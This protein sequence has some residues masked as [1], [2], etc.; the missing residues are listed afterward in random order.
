MKAKRVRDERLMLTLT[1]EEREHIENEAVK[2]GMPMTVYCRM[3]LMKAK[4]QLKI[5]ET[6]SDEQL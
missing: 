3:V 6:G 2:C 5:K 4:S 1:K